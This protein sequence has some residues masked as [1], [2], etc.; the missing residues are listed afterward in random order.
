MAFPL[1]VDRLEKEEE[2]SGRRKAAILSLQLLCGQLFDLCNR[3]LLE[4][5]SAGGRKTL[6]SR[7]LWTFIVRSGGRGYKAF[8]I[9]SVMGMF[10][11]LLSLREDLH[12]FVGPEFLL[13]E[14]GA[15]IFKRLSVAFAESMKSIAGTKFFFV[16]R[17]DSVSERENLPPF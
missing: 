9:K 15:S 14:H 1:V 13:T 7:T 17:G 2:G 3:V 10:P 11:V 8:Q 4:L 12:T 5:F 6:L 16:C